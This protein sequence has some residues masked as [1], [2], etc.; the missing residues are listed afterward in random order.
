MEFEVINAKYIKDYKIEL[1]FENGKHGIVDFT[2]YV[3]NNDVFKSFNDINFFKNFKIEFGSLIWGN[4][5]L[6]IAPETL[7]EKATGE[8]VI[9]SKD[10]ISI[11]VS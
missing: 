11:K 5:E 6:D 3:G 2:K 8:K 4:G 10:D 9:F 1:F 7:Y